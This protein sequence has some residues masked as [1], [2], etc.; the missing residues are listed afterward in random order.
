M[1]KK[2]KLEAWGEGEWIDEPDFVEF[3]HEGIKCKII[4][5]ALFGNYLCGYVR[6][7]ETFEGDIDELEV[8][9][10]ITYNNECE[11]EHWIGFDCA[12]ANDLLP[13]IE[14]MKKEDESYRKYFEDCAK[15]F[16]PVYRNMEFVIKE[17]KSLA[18]QLTSS[19]T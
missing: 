19:P 4:R 2:K 14:M 12:H 16:N 18:E 6:V 9:G 10:G 8:H 17:T 7:P 3:E 11:N 1:D 5:R 13:S 15:N